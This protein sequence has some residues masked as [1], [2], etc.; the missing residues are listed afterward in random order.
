MT[1]DGIGDTHVGNLS[2][3]MP[4]MDFKTGIHYGCISQHALDQDVLNDLITESDDLLYDQSKDD[5]RNDLI[6][7]VQKVLDDNYI[8]NVRGEDINFDDALDEW[9]ESYMNDNHHWYYK[10]ENYILDFSDDL[11]TVTIIKSPYYTWCKACSICVPNAGDLDSPSDSH[12]FRIVGD[13]QVDYYP[14]SIKTYCFPEEY[15]D[16]NRAPYEYYMVNGDIKV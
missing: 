11:V 8:E 7:A 13:K 10:D 16:N 4:N 12:T 1:N 5:F 2:S 6:N 9:E 3:L 14:H 15:F